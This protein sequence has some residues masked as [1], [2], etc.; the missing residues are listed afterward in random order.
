MTND[1]P[2]DPAN[3]Y[4][5]L[6]AELYAP[7]R[8][9]TT[10]AGPYA[11]FIALAGEPALELGCGD[12][13]PLLELR[14][15]GIDVEGVDSSSDMLERCRRAATADALDVVVH[16]Q[17]MEDL[18]LPRRF[19]SIFLA[20]STFNLLIDDETA[21]RTLARI[22]SH[23][24]EGGSALVPLFV[25][26][27]TPPQVLGVARE[28]TEADGSM[29]RVTVV[30]EQRDEVQRIQR[31]VLRYERIRSDGASA[32]LERTWILHWHTQEGFRALAEAVSLT[33]VAVLDGTGQPARPDADS[34]A[35]WLQPAS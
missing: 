11:R 23:L 27:P 3:F 15:A 20:G 30:S 26:S 12:G 8:S 25:P 17:R 28:A 16:H 13:H 6:V 1:N 9:T 21:A 22:H 24:A 18:D 31:S 5:G 29:I 34:F 10:D 14:R 32:A 33:T 7:L 35:F 2:P 19:R 4:T